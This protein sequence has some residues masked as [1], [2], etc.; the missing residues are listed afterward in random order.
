[1]LYTD[2]CRKG[3]RLETSTID[4]VI[5]GICGV[6]R[7]SK[8]L[9]FLRVDVKKHELV[10]KRM[11]YEF[12]VKLLCQEG[13]LEEALKQQAEMVGKGFEPNFEIYS[14]FIDVNTKQWNHKLTG[15][16][17]KKMI[18]LKCLKRRLD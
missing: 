8:A 10:P 12:L 16:S 6:N 14:A 11:S 1:M 3:L 15:M 17:K 13:R 4:T 5:E 2:M 9:K 7:V 18:E